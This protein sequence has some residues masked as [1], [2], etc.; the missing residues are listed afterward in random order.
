MCC[1]GAAHGA[2]RLLV[3]AVFLAGCAGAAPLSPPGTTS[4]IAR[5]VT[6]APAQAVATTALSTPSPSPQPTRA[7]ALPLLAASSTVT[8]TP[9]PAPIARF[10]PRIVAQ[11]PH[12]PGAFTQGI[13]I[14]N[15]RVFESTGLNGRSSLREVRL[16]DGSVMRKRDIEAEYFAEGLAAAN[17]R[18]YQLTWTEKTGWIYDPETFDRLAT[19]RYTTQGWGLTYDGSQ[20]IMSDGSAV[21]QFLDLASLT[22]TR[23]VTVTLDGV[24]VQRLNELEFIDGKVYA[25]VW[26]TNDIMIIDPASGRVTAVIDCQGLLGVIPAEAK[27]DVLN[28][29]AYDRD[30]SRLFLTGKLWPLLFEVTLERV[31]Q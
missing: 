17:G 27:I 26:Q 25:N 19:W 13:L 28:G 2:A 12:D 1:I 11:Y 30:A 23:T 15:G 8:A 14:E 7:V 16:E 9:P 21:L 18:L 6:A 20:L 10:V 4:S 29:I 31:P 22:P 24:P 3:F 5:P